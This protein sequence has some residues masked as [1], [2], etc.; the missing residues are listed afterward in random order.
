[1]FWRGLSL[2][3]DKRLQPTGCGCAP[4]A[5]QVRALR[6]ARI[7]GTTIPRYDI[8]IAHQGDVEEALQTAKW[9]VGNHITYFTEKI[10]ELKK[11]PE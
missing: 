3:P 9:L 7:K 11:R 2:I 4:V 8:E 1:M 6:T 5:K 10:A